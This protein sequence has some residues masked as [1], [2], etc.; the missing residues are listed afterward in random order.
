MFHMKRL[1]YLCV[2]R[3][4]QSAYHLKAKRKDEERTPTF[5]QLPLT[6]LPNSINRRH[7]TLNSP[8]NLIHR[9][10]HNPLPSQDVRR[11]LGL[12]LNYTDPR[13]GRAAIM[14]AVAQI[15]QPGLQGGRVVFLYGLQVG[16]DVGRTGD[17]GPSAADRVQEGHV[18]FG[19]VNGEVHCFA[20]EEVGVEEEIDASI[21]LHIML[22][23]ID[24]SIHEYIPL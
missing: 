12:E 22:A 5:S 1:G 13:I 2:R 14:H 17:G 3:P 23:P 9:T 20:G 18:D 21:F 19:G 10:T 11:Q 7:V 16:D 6:Q 24:R 4:K 8:L 15:T